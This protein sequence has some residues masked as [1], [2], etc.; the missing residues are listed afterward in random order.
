MVHWEQDGVRPESDE[1]LDPAAVSSATY[2]CKFTD[3]TF[4]DAERQRGLPEA[5]MVVEA[6]A[7]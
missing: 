3:N 1:V 4:T 5:R 7:P 2:G 6:C